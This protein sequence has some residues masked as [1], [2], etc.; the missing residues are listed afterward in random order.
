[1]DKFYSSSNLHNIPFL[2]QV[3][4]PKLFVVLKTLQTYHEL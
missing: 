4:N 3:S 2:S 1:M